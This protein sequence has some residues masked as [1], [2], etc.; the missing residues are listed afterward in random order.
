MRASV[1]IALMLLLFAAPSAVCAYSPKEGNVSATLG[2]S[3]LQTNFDRSHSGAKAAYKPN[4]ALIVVGDINDRAQLE[5]GTYHIYKQYFRDLNSVYVGEETEAVEI[6]LGYRHWINPWLSMAVAFSSAYSMGDVQV[7]H[8]DFA[9]G[10]AIDTSARD[11]VEYG[12]HF[13]AQAD[14]WTYE[15]FTAV[16]NTLY[17]LNVTA[18]PNEKA[19]HYGVV[20]GFRYFIQEKQVL[21]R[22]K[23]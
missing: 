21:E 7:F 8:N 5:I 20:I 4:F 9:P 19:D 17:S 11:N 2:L 13:S 18:K 16:L 10:P 14:L 12:F 15:R 6:T 22:P 3:I 23:K 1:T